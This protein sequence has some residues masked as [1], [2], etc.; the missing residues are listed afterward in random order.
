[1]ALRRV[2]IVL[3]W[4][5]IRL[6]RGGMALRW[7]VIVLRPGVIGLQWVCWDG[8]VWGGRMEGW[9]G[10]WDGVNFVVAWGVG[11]G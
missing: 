11:V 3:R 5:V 2:V 7:G 10:C 4:G 6:R 1:M 8:G 9:E